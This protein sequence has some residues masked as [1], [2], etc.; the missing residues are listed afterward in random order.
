M[1]NIAVIN[2]EAN[3]NLQV[4][5]DAY[6]QN[7]LKDGILTLVATSSKD[8]LGRA[9]KAGIGILEY[10]D[11][12]R[13]L[14]AALDDAEPDLVVVLDQPHHLSADLLASYPKQVIALHPALAGEFPGANAVQQAYEAFQRG[15]IKWSGCNIH[16]VEPEGKRGP[17]LR[18][19]VVPVESKDTPERFMARMRKSEEWLL[20]KAVKQ[21]LYELRTQKKTSRN[22][23]H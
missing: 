5:L 11:D 15:E 18:Q 7:N 20:L 9:S 21:V 1:P 10:S 3:A 17:V 13:A 14:A 4:L 12:E 16:F 22:A 23:V 19:L 2:A 8:I 6:T